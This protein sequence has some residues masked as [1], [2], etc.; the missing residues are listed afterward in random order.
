M[1][2]KCPRC[3]FSQPKDKYCAQCG[4]DIENFQPPK[5]PLLTRIFGDP[6]LQLST[7]VL[8]AIGSGF[9]VY[10]HN[11]Q[12]IQDRV[13]FF[14]QG[15]QYNRNM[16]SSLP[17]A[18]APATEGQASSQ[19]SEIPAQ[20]TTEADEVPEKPP[21]PP[22]PPANPAPEIPAKN[23]DAKSS[24][25]NKPQIQIQY[26]EVSESVR[27]QIYAD[28]RSSGLFN[29]L[30]DHE[31]GVWPQGKK[32]ISG[33]RGYQALGKETKTFEVG[34]TLQFFVGL[35]GSD[36]EN[37]LGLTTYFEVT[38]LDNQGLH[39]HLEVVRAWREPGPDNANAIQR[40]FYPAPVELTG[41]SIFFIAGVLPRGSAMDA[42]P[43]LTNIDPFKILK[44]NS[45]KNR[46]SEFLIALDFDK[47]NQ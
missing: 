17:P 16:T 44:T 33:L 29:S 39:G 6:F 36:P 1:M 10:K 3:G 7:V 27:E 24:E 15:I 42:D 37:D 45:F 43:Y 30:G 11:R 23:A 20:L 5:V 4:L 9:Y 2:I 28:S 26:V 14:R 40:R 18:A 19:S 32:K 13:S 41:E 21:A 47:A 31:A 46:L 12:E 38:G 34:R 22:P 8:I 35:K 25:S